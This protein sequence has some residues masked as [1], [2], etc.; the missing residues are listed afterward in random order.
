MNW[1]Q[2]QWREMPMRSLAALTR[3]S[4]CLLLAC[5]AACASHAGG[6]AAPAAIVPADVS[7]AVKQR[8]RAARE[9]EL[10]DLQV[11][12]ASDGTVR[13]SGRT[14]TQAM[15]DMATQIAR[16]TPGVTRVRSDILAA[17]ETQR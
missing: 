17:P 15:A 1:I 11:E 16:T 10:S 4:V 9:R 3:T 5:A 12:T 14:Y 8:L 13:L 7:A 2:R 6:G